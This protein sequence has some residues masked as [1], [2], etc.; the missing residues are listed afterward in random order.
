MTTKNM[1][2]FNDAPITKPEKDRF[3][4]DTFAKAISDCIRENDNPVGSVVAIYGPWGSGKSSTINLVRHHLCNS[5]E[6]INV[7]NFPAWIYHNEDALVAGFFKD[8]RV[9]LSPVLSKQEKASEALRK[10][11]VHIAGAGNTVGAAIGLFAGSLGEKATNDIFKALNQF[12]QS[13]ENAENLQ[14]QLADALRKEQKKFLVVIDD[15]DRLAPEEALVIFRLIKSVGCLPN[16][17]YLLAYDRDATEKAVEE[18]FKSEGAHYL[19]KIVQAGFELPNPDQ[20][21]LN[22]MMGVYLDNIIADLPDTDINELRK[23]FR[24][25]VVPELKTPRDVIRLANTLSIVVNPIKDEVFFPDIMSLETL[26]IFHPKVY[27]AIRANKS[28][29][30]GLLLAAPYENRSELE[31][32]FLQRLLGSEAENERKR[33]K[34]ILIRLFPQLQSIFADTSY[35]EAWQWKSQRRVCSKEHF[36]TY[37]RFA[38]SPEAIP[39]KELDYLLDDKRTVED[40]QQRFIEAMKVTQAEN[41]SKASYLLDEL[42]V[43]GRNVP[44]SHAELILSAIFPIADKIMDRD[45]ERGFGVANNR[46]RIHWLLRAFLFDSTTINQRSKILMRS[47]EKASLQWLSDFSRSAWENHHPSKPDKQPSPEDKTLLTKEDAEDMREKGRRQIKAAAEDGTLIDATELVHILFEWDVLKT[48]DSNEVQR[49][50]ADAI[51]DDKKIVKLARAFRGKVY[52]TNASTN[53]NSP[54]GNISS[55]EVDRA[56]IDDIDRLLDRDKFRNRLMSLETSTSLSEEERN[57]ISRFL[58]AWEARDKEDNEGNSI[59]EE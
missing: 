26:R 24:L 19:E 56:Q 5:G 39:R 45:K 49:F 4:F 47:M 28:E 51:A 11:G 12:A 54:E 44:T 34:V 43:H 52:I 58:R 18:K 15:L 40:I 13:D 3:G 55:C 35:S 31:K 53:G 38:L 41:R 32:T 37:F 46:L 22:N 17:M 36:D 57:I 2:S 20:S 50:T 6:D 16:V 21:L 30:L 14:A 42:T 33:L 8:L 7:I 1:N 27:R 10:L 23:L 48:D 9:G 29:I 25:V 59:P